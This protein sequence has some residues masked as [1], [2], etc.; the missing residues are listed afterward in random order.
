MGRFI[1]WNLFMFMVWSLAEL[2]S[3]TCSIESTWLMRT[4]GLVCLVVDF[5][6]NGRLK[7]QSP[8]MREG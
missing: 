5:S 7:P 4:T 1:S 2:K 3:V 6:G 8:V